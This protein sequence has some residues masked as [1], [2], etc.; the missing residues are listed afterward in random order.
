MVWVE[1]LI[2]PFMHR[3]P[4]LF[5]DYLNVDMDPSTMGWVLQFS[6]RTWL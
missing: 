2:Q 1:L 6:P 5:V 3:F 4:D